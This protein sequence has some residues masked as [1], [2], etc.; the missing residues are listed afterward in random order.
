[1]S[2]SYFIDVRSCQQTGTFWGETDVEVGGAG[3]GGVSAWSS[4]HY[5]QSSVVI[6]SLLSTPKIN[7]Y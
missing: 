3:F 5:L 4:V 1:M 2:D 7:R 6:A